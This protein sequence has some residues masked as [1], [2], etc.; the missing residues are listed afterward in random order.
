MKKIILISFLVFFNV[1]AAR[2][3]VKVGFVDLQRI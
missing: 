2:A 3:D 1:V